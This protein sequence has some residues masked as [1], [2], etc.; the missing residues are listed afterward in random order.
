MT[1]NVTKPALNI[2]E[3][4]AELDKPS[5]IAGEA[6]LRADSVQEQRNLIGAGRKNLII[7]GAMQVAQRGTSFTSYSGYTIDRYMGFGH[8]Y[9]RIDNGDF[10][11]L[12]STYVS[13]TVANLYYPVELQKGQLEN[14][15]VYTMSF[16]YKKSGSPLNIE[17]FYRVGTSGGSVVNQITSLDLAPKSE[18]TKFTMTFTCKGR[19]SVHTALNIRF[20]NS[21][22]VLEIAELQLELGSVATDFEHRSY[23]EEL[24]LCQRYFYTPYQTEGDDTGLMFAGAK[25]STQIIGVAHFPV[26]M[27]TSPS[28]VNSSA[29]FR[30]DSQASLQ[31]NTAGS[32]VVIEA[33]GPTS[34]LIKISGFSGLS[35]GDSFPCKY[36]AGT[37]AFQS[38]L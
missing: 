37:F 4:L 21:D 5:G 28:V 18:F 1:V 10:Y 31:S 30:V 6:M 29:Q 25:T 23:G 12:R 19:L 8:D 2:R 13:G 22:G 34:G 20:G 26:A 16:R 36:V 38:E 35:S 17:M 9:E 32:T 14:D 3:K 11:S 33:G 15:Q 7:N 24:A 27:R